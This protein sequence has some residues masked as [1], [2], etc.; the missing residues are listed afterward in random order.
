MWSFGILLWEIYSFGRVPYPRIVSIVT[1]ALPCTDN[2]IPSV[3][4]SFIPP[5]ASSGCGQARR[6]RLQDGSP[7]GLSAGNLRDDAPGVGPR[8]GEAAHLCG[9]ETTASHL[10]AGNGQHLRHVD[11]RVL[12]AVVSGC[13]PTSRFSIQN[14]AARSSK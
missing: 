5:L 1:A 3:F 9:A 11:S 13:H 6:Q 8:A 7:R 14:H 4:F 2:P 10:Q 12:D